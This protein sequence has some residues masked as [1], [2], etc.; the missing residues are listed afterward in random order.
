MYVLTPADDLVKPYILCRKYSG[1]DYVEVLRH[2]LAALPT[3]MSDVS[4]S[5]D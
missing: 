4:T 3:G 2:S 5:S 1:Y